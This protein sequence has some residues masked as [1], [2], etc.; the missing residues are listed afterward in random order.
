MFVLNVNEI[1]Y[2]MTKSLLV[3]RIDESEALI[4]TETNNAA[5]LK[6]NN[7]VF[8]CYLFN[9]VKYVFLMIFYFSIN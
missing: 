5:G 8:I 1:V 4:A 7:F 2:L 3:K 9:Y 6:I